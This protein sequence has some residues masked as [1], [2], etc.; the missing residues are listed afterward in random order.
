MHTGP[1]I[2]L[3]TLLPA[4]RRMIRVAVAGVILSLS[5]G[6]LLGWLVSNAPH[7]ALALALGNAFM[8]GGPAAFNAPGAAQL[9][10]GAGLVWG[11]GILLVATFPYT[12]WLIYHVTRGYQQHLMAHRMQAYCRAVEDQQPD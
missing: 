1:S 10:L 4:K 8:A 11:L 9:A 6:L 7:G 12:A 2:D 3:Y 5:C